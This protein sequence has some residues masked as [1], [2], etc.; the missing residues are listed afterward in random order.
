VVDERQLDMEEFKR[1]FGETQGSQK[2]MLIIEA[3]E[4]TL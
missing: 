1:L 4:E 3:K 2:G